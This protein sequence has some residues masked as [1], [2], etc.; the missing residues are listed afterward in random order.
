MQIPRSNPQPLFASAAAMAMAAVALL[1]TP[2]D[3]R[4]FAAWQETGAPQEGEKKD[5][6]G[7]DEKKKEEKE[8]WFAL[9]H[10][11]VY[12]GTGSV[13]RG[14]SILSKNGVIEKI[15]YD[16]EVPEGAKTLEVPGLRVYPGLVAISSSGLLGNTGSD[17]ADTVD[18]FNS[19]MVLAL[20][21]G[22]TSTGQGAAACKLKRYEIKGVVI[23]DKYLTTFSY[24]DSNPAGKRSL[25]EKLDAAAK[26][27]REYRD[28]EEKKKENKDLKEPPRKG[29]DA[30]VLS[31]LK[32]E[33]LARFNADSREDLLALARLAQRYGFRP[34][35]D[36][37]REG[38]TVA[39]ELGRAGAYAIVTPR[40]RDDKSEELV[41]PGGSSIENAAILHKHGVQVCVIPAAK[42]VDLGGIVGR[43]ILHLPI[44]AGFAVRG[45]LPESAALA[46]ITIVPARILGVDYRV[47]SLEV[48]KDLDA[49]V[50][51][52]DVL[53]YQTFVQYAV[54]DGKQVY[55]KEKELWFAHI[56]PRPTAALAPT[57][58]TDAGEEP[59]PEKAAAQPPSEKPP[60]EKPPEDKP[61][62]KP[63]EKKPD[64]PPPDPPPGDRDS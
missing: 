17:F 47:G 64:V 34:V 9:L 57:E 5:G 27:L 21:S 11:D 29:V 30:A 63:P 3:A 37:C 43:D 58:R 42:G 33:T 15:G 6:E 50:T 45:G 41:R 61:E 13:L 51:D 59:A 28:W 1:A 22:V 48:G 19:R 31:V 24:T 35:I 7:A 2:A 25:L 52:G 49:I 26:Y 60:G 4:A 44:E 8:E 54:V 10:G 36:G 12:T 16:L 32:A 38:W 56:R 53:H 23:R 62:E 55:D 18:P 40:D 14:A 39:D 46:A 20:A